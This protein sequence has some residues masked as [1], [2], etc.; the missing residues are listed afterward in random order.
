MAFRRHRVRLP[1]E[2][3]SPHP[4]SREGTS[5]LSGEDAV[6]FFRVLR[7]VSLLTGV[8]S[9]TFIWPSSNLTVHRACPSGAGPQTVAIIMASALPSTLRRAW[10]EFTLRFRV[11]TDSMPPLLYILTMFATV[12]MLIP[13]ELAHSA[14]LRT[15]GWASSKSSSILHL[16]ANVSFVDR[17][18]SIDLSN[19]TFSSVRLTEYCFGLAIDKSPFVVNDGK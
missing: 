11:M 16:F 18:R 17:F 5:S 6:C 8:S 7:R 15:G 2:L 10:S 12:P 4:P 19:A 9:S 13:C 3:R 14:C 1:C